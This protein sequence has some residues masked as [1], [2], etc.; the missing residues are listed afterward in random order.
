MKRANYLLAAAML[1]L[2][3]ASAKA[4]GEKIAV[5]T[6]NLTNPHFQL[7]R[8]GADAAAKQMNAIVT[9]YVPSKPDN[10]PEQM[11][12]LE[13]LVIKKPDAIVFVPADFKAMVPGIEKLNA[14][15]IPLVNVTTRL[16]G[17]KVVAFVGSNDYDLGLATG[18][19]LLK[20]MGGKGNVII[21]EGL[22]GN[23]VSMDRVRGFT[24]ALKEAP[25]VKLLASQTG[26]FQRLPANQVM[27]NLLQAHAKVDGV[28]VANDAMASGVI[29]ALDGAG[30]K[31]LVVGINGTKEAIDG[32][33]SGKLVATADYSSFLQG[34]FAAM[35][36]IR[37]LRKLPVGENLVFP[38]TLIDKDNAAKFDIPAE[39]RSCPAWETAG[40]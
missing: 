14:A 30:R 6:T 34:C 2:T 33:K 11:S 13:D 19:H 36:A 37:T 35:S 31:A 27:E 7:V 12:Q 40:K 17:G 32:V 4:D 38:A 26:N 16:S 8:M 29:E 28:M 23:I 20:A 5:M 25:E 18:R 1:P 22:K 3:L 24:D 15:G 21:I 9:H 10:I 39:G